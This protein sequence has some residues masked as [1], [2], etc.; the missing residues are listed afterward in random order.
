MNLTAWLMA[1]VGPIIARAMVSLGVSLVTFAGVTAAVALLKSQVISN[2]GGLPA[3]AIQL[4]G[5][6]GIWQ[7]L[8]M[9]FGAITFVLAFNSTRMWAVVKSTALVP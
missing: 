7:G 3:A 4:G 2:I 6:F 9:V 1:M 8:G 5:L